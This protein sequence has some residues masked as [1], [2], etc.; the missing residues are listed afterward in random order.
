MAAFTKAFERACEAIK[1]GQGADIQKKIQEK[2][3]ILVKIK[4]YDEE[5]KI[6]KAITL[7]ERQ[8]NSKQIHTEEI[9]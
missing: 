9:L 5:A 1:E 7:T 4:A 3:S 2:P 8:K 6:G